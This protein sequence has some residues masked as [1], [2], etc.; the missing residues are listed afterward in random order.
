MRKLIS[1][2][3]GVRLTIEVDGK[4]K[5]LEYSSVCPSKFMRQPYDILFY[6]KDWLE[7][8]LEKDIVN[9]HIE[10]AKPVKIKAPNQISH[11]AFNRRVKKNLEQLGYKE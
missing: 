1:M 7:S 2:N 4:I 5:E 9:E 6:L 10:I 3:L 8:N 11:K